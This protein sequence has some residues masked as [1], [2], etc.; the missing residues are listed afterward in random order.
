MSL[1]KLFLTVSLVAIM[2]ATIDTIARAENLDPETLLNRAM[3]HSITEEE[4]LKAAQD[5]YALQGEHQL[6]A[7]RAYLALAQDSRLTLE[8][9]IV[10]ASAFK[11]FDDVYKE[12]AAIILQSIGLD[13]TIPPDYA[14]LRFQAA[15]SLSALGEKYNEYTASIFQCLGKDSGVEST[16]RIAAIYR[17]ESLGDAYKN[18]ALEI[19]RFL[20]KEPSIPLE[21]HAD[22]AEI[23]SHFGEEHKAEA[24]KILQ[25]VIMNSEVTLEN[26]FNTLATLHDFNDTGEYTK[27][28]EEWYLS[29]AHDKKF[30][31]KTRIDCL[32]KGVLLAV[33][34]RRPEAEK[35]LESFLEDLDVCIAAAN[36]IVDLELELRMLG[37]NN[38]ILY[39]ALSLARE[40]GPNHPVSLFKA[41]QKKREGPLVYN[42]PTST[43]GGKTVTFTKQA[44]APKMPL[45]SLPAVTQQDVIDLWSQLLLEIKDNNSK[46]ARAFYDII[47]DDFVSLAFNELDTAKD[48]ISRQVNRSF[49]HHNL[50]GN[51]ISPQDL[52]NPTVVRLHHIVHSIKNLQAHPMEQSVVPPEGLSLASQQLAKLLSL[53]LNCQAGKEYGVEEAYHLLEKKRF[54][55][56]IE[57][58]SSDIGSEILAEERY[59]REDMYLMKTLYA[60]LEH[61]DSQASTA[62]NM[63]EPIHQKRYLRSLLGKAIGLHYEG[64]RVPFDAHG[65]IIHDKLRSLSQEEALAKFFGYYTPE[66][67]VQHSMQFLN[68]KLAEERQESDMQKKYRTVGVLSEIFKL[69]QIMSEEERQAMLSNKHDF[70]M[71]D[72]DEIGM[73]VVKSIKNPEKVVDVLVYL[74]LLKEL[75][76]SPG[77]SSVDL[78]KE[79]TTKKRKARDQD[80]EGPEGERPAKRPRIDNH[81]MIA[82]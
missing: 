62:Q 25:S 13:S 15:E 51:S 4:R 36:K 57:I 55:T 44:F 46:A 12:K 71:E 30:D 24:V 47:K 22:I 37:N 64:E 10:A 70:D 6:H 39:K 7:I 18:D 61:S 45:L 81:D 3:D 77:E 76:S 27:W 33:P 68:S 21:E 49:Y 28:I 80:G 82:E 73:V 29:I 65:E 66:S 35:L 79:I 60:A 48:T 42:F 54:L 20:I 50:K 40:L 74:G 63:E 67:M 43:M 16:V 32:Y 72:N 31:I 2:N 53:T 17:L 14:R 11:H 58:E 38:P 5:L 23:L 9:R 59:V 26:R 69:N 56:P 19:I 1:N 8:S 78:E 52:M 34:A 41:L 75:P